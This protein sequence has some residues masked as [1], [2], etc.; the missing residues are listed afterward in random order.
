MRPAQVI[1][2]NCRRPLQAEWVEADGVDAEW[3]DADRAELRSQ[4]DEE[5]W[6]GFFYLGGASWEAPRK[7]YPKNE[8]W[9]FPHLFLF[10]IWLI[11]QTNFKIGK[12]K[13][14]NQNKISKKWRV[15]IPT[16]IFI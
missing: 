8:W 15:E 7:K 9:T 14:L 1:F 3:V 13:M 4:E 2:L 10:K 6:R 5:E 12:F 16:L 11:V